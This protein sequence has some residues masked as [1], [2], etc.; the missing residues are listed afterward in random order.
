[1]DLLNSLGS[2]MGGGKS[3]ASLI[4]IVLPLL[5][6]AG[7]LDGLMKMFEGA[8]LG[9]I[10]QSWIGK[11]ENLPISAAQVSQVF[12]GANGLLGQVAKETGVAPDVAAGQLSTA[13]PT[14]VDALSPDGGMPTGNLM[15]LAKSAMSSGALGKLLG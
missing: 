9:N 6:K 8:G 3:P 14:L 5:Q 11:G 2:A 7:G 4:T 15:D 12:G 10:L 13:L 1:V